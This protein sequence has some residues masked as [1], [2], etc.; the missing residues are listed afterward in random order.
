M[1]FRSKLQIDQDSVGRPSEPAS[2][3]ALFNRHVNDLSNTL[4]VNLDF[5]RHRPKMV[6]VQ[7]IHESTTH[8]SGP[9]LPFPRAL[10]QQ[11]GSNSRYNGSLV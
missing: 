4:L 8:S 7:L 11:I 3:T 1:R 5:S 9:A 6:A 2:G 10:W